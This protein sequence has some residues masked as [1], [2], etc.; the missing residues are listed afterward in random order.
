MRTD[1]KDI[2]CSKRAKQNTV[3]VLADFHITATGATLTYMKHLNVRNILLRNAKHVVCCA[4]IC[5][6]L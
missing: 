1:D 4:F 6:P 2:Y 5:V 3:D